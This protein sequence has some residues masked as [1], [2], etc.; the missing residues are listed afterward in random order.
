MRCLLADVLTYTHCF[1]SMSDMTES[2]IKDL[3][4][5]HGK[6]DLVSLPKNRETGQPRGFAFVDMNTPEEMKAAIAAMDGQTVNGRVVRASESVPKD[7]AGG[8]R[9]S[10]PVFEKPQLPEGYKKIYVGNI[11]FDC[12]REEI[13]EIYQKYGDVTE[14]YIPR[15]ANT[16]N[17]RG[18][19]FVTM[20]EDKADQAIEETNGQEMGGRKLVVS[21]PL[22]PG[23]KA[24][25]RDRAFAGRTKLYIGN[26]SFYTVK[27]TLLE[28]FEEFGTVHDCYLPE[29]PSTGGSRGFGFVTLDKEVASTAIA[30]LDGCEVDGRV[31]RVNE[32]QP[33]RRRNYDD[34]ED[35]E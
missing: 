19:A 35:E 7:E 34:E 16:G 14:V 4:D 32:A 1:A 24:P 2:S 30:E 26:L 9:Q 28:M 29:D 8:D 18:F 21:L 12:T 25:A 27:D 20:E 22:P 17:G 23:K 11:P 31:I 6:V 33:K 15:D 5:Q 3:F 10:K 13:L